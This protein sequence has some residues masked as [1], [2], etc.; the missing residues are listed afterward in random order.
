MKYQRGHTLISQLLASAFDINTRAPPSESSSKENTLNN[1]G[2]SKIF[3]GTSLEGNP[4]HCCCSWLQHANRRLAEDQQISRQEKEAKGSSFSLL[5]ISN[6][7][8]ETATMIVRRWRASL[9]A[10]VRHSLFVSDEV[11]VEGVERRDGVDDEVSK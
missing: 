6:V 11:E 5:M 3:L 9:L 1:C 7:P 8:N 10:Y 4:R 2:L